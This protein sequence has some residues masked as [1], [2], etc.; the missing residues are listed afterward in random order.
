MKLIWTQRVA[1]YLGGLTILAA[2][3][4][5]PW[6]V[7]VHAEADWFMTNDPRLFSRCEGARRY[8]WLFT[9]PAAPAVERE[10]GPVDKRTV[11]RWESAE[12]DLPMLAVQC[13]AVA[14][15]TGL[16]VFAGFDLRDRQTGEGT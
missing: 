7:T 9:P 1:I 8:S 11:T 2:L 15:A 4:C 16:A 10:S 6:R 13:L 3:V 14:V 5:P 12:I